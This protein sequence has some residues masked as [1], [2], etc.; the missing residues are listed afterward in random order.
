MVQEE[1][2]QGGGGGGGGGLIPGYVTTQHEAEEDHFEPCPEVTAHISFDDGREEKSA[3]LQLVTPSGEKTY[4]GVRDLSLVSTRA[5]L[6]DVSG[7]EEMDTIQLSVHDALN[8]AMVVLDDEK[9]LEQCIRRHRYG[10]A[11]RLEERLTAARKRLQSQVC[12]RYRGKTVEDDDLLAALKGFHRILSAVSF[13]REGEV[14]EREGE[15][16]RERD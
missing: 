6:G 1:A 4:E 8:D 14:G 16:E 15:R 11:A 7:L 10:A 5:V 3:A 9:L 12:S 13:G 2:D